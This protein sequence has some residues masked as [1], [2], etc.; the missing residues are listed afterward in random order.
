MSNI[1]IVVSHPDDEVLGSGGYIFKET[2]KGN[3]VNLLVL[4]GDV[5]ARKQKPSKDILNSNILSSCKILGIKN[6][7]SGKFTNI[8]FNIV[9]HLK[10]VK[11]IENYIE[12]IQPEIIITHHPSD[13]NSDHH[14]TSIACQAALRI[15]QRKINIKHV[16]KLLFMEV[17]SSTEWNI[18]PSYSPFVPNYFYKIGKNGLET[19]IK[20][21]NAYLNVMRPYPHPRSIESITA[22]AT[23]R[24]SQSGIELA[25]AFQIG[26]IRDFY[27][28]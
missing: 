8:E 3:I 25:E 2:Q 18:N 22:L 15:T 14:Y 4:S 19:K 23:L 27:Y 12:T 5:S 26:L 6:Y 7:Y 13:L 16:K 11:F 1:L 10:L 9:S 17:L 21:L 20:A 24:G 28:D